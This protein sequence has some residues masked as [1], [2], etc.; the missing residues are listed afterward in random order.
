MPGALAVIH[1][2]VELCVIVDL[3]GVLKIDYKAG[4]CKQSRM[5]VIFYAETKSIEAAAK[6]KTEPD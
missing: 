6:F 4:K 1:E 2:G 3:K 5:R